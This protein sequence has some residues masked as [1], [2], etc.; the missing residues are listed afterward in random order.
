MNFYCGFNS[1]MQWFNLEKKTRSSVI[2][3]MVN[4]R[5]TLAVLKGFFPPQFLDNGLAYRTSHP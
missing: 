5:Q 2:M 3:Q 1:T 4:L